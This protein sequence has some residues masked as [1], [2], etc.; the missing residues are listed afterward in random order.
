[1]VHILFIFFLC[2]LFQSIDCTQWKFTAV[3]QTQVLRDEITEPFLLT[4]LS[5]ECDI[6][7]LR[8]EFNY[9]TGLSVGQKVLP[10]D[11]LQALGN[12]FQK[13]CFDSITLTLN[14]Q[15]DGKKAHFDLHGFWRFDSIKISGVWV[16]KEWYKQFYLMEAGDPFDVEQHM[17]SVQKMKEA[18]IQDGF[19]DVAAKSTFDRNAKTKAVTVHTTINRGKRF[20]VRKI[21]VALIADQSMIDRDK[22]VLQRLIE[23][24]LA[25]GLLHAKYSKKG[26]ELQEKGLKELLAQ[27]GFLQASIAVKEE[28]FHGRRAVF[29]KWTIDLRKKRAFIFEGNR[30]F[31]SGQLLDHVLQF[32]RSSSIVP[33]SILAQD[34]KEAY[35]RKG[36]WNCTIDARDDQHCSRFIINEGLRARITKVVLQGAYQLN[37]RKLRKHCFG[38]LKRHA[39]YD[40]E[41]LDQ[42][43]DLLVDQYLKE[44]FLDAAIEHHECLPLEDSNA[45]TLQITVKEGMQTQIAHVSIPGYEQYEAQGPFAAINRSKHPVAYDAAI[46]QEQKRFLVGK[47]QKDGYLF[48]K[49]EHEL[50]AQ[51][52]AHSLTWKIDPGAHICFGKTIL[53]SNSDLPAERIIRELSFKEGASWDSEK[54]KQSFVRLKSLNLFDS[55][56]FTPLAVKEGHEERDLLL[57]IRKDDP[58]ELRIRAGLEFQHVRQYQTFAGVAYKV[59]GTFMVKNITNHADLFRF[60]ADVARS[61]R[62]VH[63]KYMYPWVFN[64]PIDGLLDGYA[65][66]YEQP[67][68]IGSK[69]NLYTLYQNG[70]LCGVRHKNNYLDFGVNGGFEVGRTTFSDDD[71]KTRQAALRLA[72]AINF[73]AR[74]LDQ[75]IAYL[76]FEPT[77]ML[78]FLD[79]N[80]YPSNGTF[81]LFSCKG[82][83]PISLKFRNTYFFKLLMEHSWF[84]PLN[85]IVAAFRVRLGH[86][87]H[88]KFKD[89]MPNERFYLGGSN[90]IR[91]YETDLAPPTGEFIDDD[92]KIHAVPRGGKSMFNLN[93]ELRIPVA[94]KAGVVIF[95]DMGVL[96]GDSFADF[97]TGKIVTGT[98]FGLRFFTPIGPLRFDIG[99]KWKKA[100]PDERRYNWVLTFGQAF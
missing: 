68:F 16:G 69:K 99:F 95:Q 18:C 45:H 80:L 64:V 75:R 47:L 92:G 12:L 93:A 63:M 52:E 17:H 30:F 6:T 48:S 7:F 26:V 1:M 81:T 8:K 90:S 36:F 50:S 59:G 35:R 88:R 14:D 60:D 31:T 9:L 46:I 70:F 33:A 27:K 3:D 98:G 55:I 77:I 25:G 65:I 24:K 43:F 67:G 87:F 76:F 5:Y 22:R 42:A 39:L 10:A 28:R 74:L 100:H 32:G 4:D 97:T 40:Q 91:S 72:E 15:Q 20:A 34:I 86:I 11:L 94:R 82:M 41:Y 57:K 79:N 56:S 66:K 2:F 84:V 73:D 21:I 44:G 58:F 78:D 53:Q 13:N 61:H 49:I 83:F 19:F 23:K 37:E 29:L 54:M 38:R 96:S 62:E 89:I 71:L 51:E 85:Q